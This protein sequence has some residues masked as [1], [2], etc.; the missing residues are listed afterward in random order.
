MD[1]KTESPRTDRGSDGRILAELAAKYT[2][3]I[4]RINDRRA[5]GA[6]VRRRGDSESV[7]VLTENYL[8][9]RLDSPSP[10]LRKGTEVRVRLTSPGKAV[11]A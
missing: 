10:G 11:L 7:T 5:V 4:R 9:A 8:T 3:G 6:I 2:C 1:M